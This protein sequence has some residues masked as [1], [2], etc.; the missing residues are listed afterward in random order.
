MQELV[1]MYIMAY[2]CTY[3]HH[4]MKTVKI[5]QCNVDMLSWQ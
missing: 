2:F 3:I 5:V 4:D 1:F